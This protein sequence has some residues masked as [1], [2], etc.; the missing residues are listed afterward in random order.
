MLID[1]PFVAYFLFTKGATKM[2]K[3]KITALY[4]RL[5]VEDERDTESVS[6][7]NQKLQL[8]EY[9]KAN[10]FTNIVHYT[11]D[12]ESGRFFDRAGYVKMMEDI[13]N[14]RVA[15]CITKDVSRLGRDYIRVGLCMD[16][17]VKHKLKKSEIFYK[18]FIMS[19]Q[20]G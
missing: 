3:T 20:Q 9:A 10:G 2:K 11:D 14:G 7:E 13:E 19:F 1:K 18:K 16:A 5:S 6:I 8:A 17:N 12:G 15:V 4:E